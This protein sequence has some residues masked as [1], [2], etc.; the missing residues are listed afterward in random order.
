VWRLVD[1]ALNRKVNVVKIEYPESDLKLIAHE[2]VHKQH[3]QS[4]G[5]LTK[6]LESDP[7][8]IAGKRALE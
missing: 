6:A 1:L 3:W 7:K 2:E 4:P 5:L 8:V